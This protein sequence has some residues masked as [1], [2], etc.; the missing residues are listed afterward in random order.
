MDYNCEIV[1]NGE[2]NSLSF[3]PIITFFFIVLSFQEVPRLNR[4]VI[5]LK[6]TATSQVRE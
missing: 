3:M 5:V 4:K 6:V 2:R 1:V